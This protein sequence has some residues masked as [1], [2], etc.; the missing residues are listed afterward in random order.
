MNTDVL[1]CVMTMLIYMI[2]GYILCKSKKGSALHI[3]TV[4]GLLI[5]I[6]NPAMILNAF[7]KTEYTP[8]T[9]INILKFFVV[10][11]ILQFLFFAL[12]YLLLHKKFE[13][14]AYRLMSIGASFGNV[15]FLGLPLVTSFFPDKPIVAC[16]STVYVLSMNLLVFTV[17]IFMITND[18]KFMSLKSAIVNPTSL[19]IFVALPLFLFRVELPAIIG[20]PID[21]LAKMV[22]PMCMIMLGMRLST[23][24]L[25]KLF[26]RP[27]VYATCAL[28]LI[29]Y[30]LFAY[31]CVYFLPFLDDSF[32][33]SILIL[34]SVPTGA[35]ISSLSELHECEQE[36]S[37]NIVLLTTILSNLTIPLV[38]LIA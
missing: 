27:F 23:V 17:G 35:V 7:L 6:L 38:L 30:P 21:L 5:Y 32:K 1:T 10:T 3:K 18:R 8:E 37:A 19:S 28:K 26:T 24:K 36:F 34:S 12:L 14:A 22:T 16:Y 2:L 33:I 13:N 20:N 4:S 9:A 15:G 25:I 11:F 29:A 31:A